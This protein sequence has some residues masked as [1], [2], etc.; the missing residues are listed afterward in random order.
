MSIGNLKSEGNKGNN[1][2]YQLKSLQ[3]LQCICDSLGTSGV[4]YDVLVKMAAYLEA[5]DRTPNIVRTS[6]TGTIPKC[7]SFSVANVGNA[8]GTFLGTTLGPGET[9]SFDAGTLNNSFPGSAYDA[10]GTTFLINYVD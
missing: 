3:G 4:L 5:Q 1:F 2:P 9:V 6:T 10:T 8:N 7:Y